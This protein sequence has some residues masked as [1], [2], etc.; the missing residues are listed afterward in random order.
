MPS[1]L[2]HVRA[3]DGTDIL[4]RDWASDAT[5]GSPW[6]SVLLVHG[7]GEHSGRY[8]HVGDQMAAAGRD[9]E[10]YDHRGNGGSG[11]RRG[12]V[13][14]WEQYLDDLAGR[15]AP[16]RASA[17]G[18]PVVLY[19]HSMGGLI[20]LGYLLTD[21]PKPDLVVLSSPALDSTLAEW[22]KSLAPTLSRIVPTLAI[23]NGI[24]GS[25]L[26]RDPA[27]AAS[28]GADPLAT[29]SSTARFG[30]EALTEQA[31]VRSEYAGLTL[32]TLVL[33]GLDDGLVPPQ[34][35]EILGSLPNVERRTYPGLRH[36]LHNEPEGPAIVGE[37]IDWIRAR[38]AERA[39]IPA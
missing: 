38:T 7:L 6:A 31:R 37:I 20:V 8:E 21:R 23:P 34:A 18:R 26:S 35:S 39:T 2:S 4:V 13:D 12:H 15:L 14:R 10:A 22:K 25:T 16:V 36:E 30:A 1:I 19:G 27:V 5:T 32:P 11:G 29:K 9:G 3:A 28:V 24:D 33:H 17:D